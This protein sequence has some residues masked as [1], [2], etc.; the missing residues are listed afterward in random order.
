M[1]AVRAAGFILFRR[2]PPKHEI[3]YLL[4]QTSYGKHHWTPPKGHV[5]PGESD[6]E[7]ALRETK[8]EAGLDQ[9]SFTVIPN[10]C[11]ELNYKVTSHRDGIERPKVV[12]Y[13]CAE[14]IDYNCQ[15][16]MSDEHQAFNWL[17]LEQAKKLSGFKDMNECF[18]KCEAKI[19]S[20]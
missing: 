1:D 5:D 6:Y 9:S 20:L 8:E 12:T 10:F 15:V 7:T 14:L 11:C 16:I 17:P 19:N 3:E 2:A 18:D 4:M 13:W